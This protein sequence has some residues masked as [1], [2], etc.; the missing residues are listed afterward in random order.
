MTSQSFAGVTPHPLTRALATRD[1]AAVR[2][3]LAPDVVFHDPVASARFQ[4]AE[5][6]A[7]VYRVLLEACEQWEWLTELA[8]EGQHA[9]VYRIRLAG[10]D[11]EVVDLLWF[12][13]QGRIREIRAMAR[14]LSGMAG[15]V[16]AVGPPLGRRNG[17]IRGALLRVAGWPATK[18]LVAIDRMGS[19][20]I[21]PRK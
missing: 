20:L 6:V 4:G 13:D 7:D 3:L 21:R 10:K 15:F 11:V 12:D 14:P 8:S 16:A 2:A 1:P 5:T 9:I 17:R 19:R 18:L